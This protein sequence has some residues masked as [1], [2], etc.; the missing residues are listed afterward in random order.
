VG[1]F[2]A[3]VAQLEAAAVTAFG[4]LAQELALQGAPPSM[5][6]AAWRSRR[7][8]IVHAR[9]MAGLARRYGGRPIAPRPSAWAPRSLVDVAIDNAAEGCVRETYGAL[10]AHVQAR[11]ARDPIARRMLGR[12]ARD[13]TRH[14]VLSWSLAR[15]AHTRMRAA[16]R[17]QVAQ[18]TREALERLEHELLQPCAPEVERIMGMP[19]PDEA[20]ALYRRMRDVLFC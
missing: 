12:I 4:Q 20:R 13:E 5:V 8:E 19:R 6:R 18:S 3:E 16:E 7:E 17:R 1:A 11:R 14:A 2:V 9:M 10:V 15:W